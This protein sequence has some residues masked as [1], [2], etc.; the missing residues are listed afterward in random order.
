M[1]VQNFN[2]EADAFF[3]GEGVH[4]AA[5]GIH[6]ARNLFRGTVCGAFEHHVLNEMRDA[7]R[8]GVSC[9]DP[10]L[11]QIPMETE[12]MCR[13]SSVRMV[14]PLGKTWRRMLRRPSITCWSAATGKSL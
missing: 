3:G 5:N 1:L 10:V 9:R 7:V 8:F 2:V 6:F 11:I 12:R 14:K 4:V 13:I